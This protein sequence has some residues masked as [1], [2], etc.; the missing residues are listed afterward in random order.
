VRVTEAEGDRDQGLRIVLA[1]DTA[2]ERTPDIGLSDA[3]LPPV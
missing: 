3:V 1:R 2:A